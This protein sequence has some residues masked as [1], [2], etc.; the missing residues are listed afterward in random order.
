MFSS[1]HKSKEFIRT[2]WTFQIQWSNQWINNDIQCQNAHIFLSLR[3]PSP[4]LSILFFFFCF[5]AIMTHSLRRMVAF[6]LKCKSKRRN[7]PLRVCVSMY[8]VEY[9][10]NSRKIAEN[11]KREKN[12]AIATSYFMCIHCSIDHTPLIMNKEVSKKKTKKKSRARHSEFL[13]A[14]QSLVFL[15]KIAM[16]LILTVLTRFDQ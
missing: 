15:M 7:C 6:K 9:N 2:V 14:P 11:K 10:V 1:P 4:S 13:Y 12:N 3:L 5:V 16:R 8:F